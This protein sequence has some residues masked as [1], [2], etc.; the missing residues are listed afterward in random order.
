MGNAI[1]PCHAANEIES[2]SRGDVLQMRLLLPDIM[3][4]THPHDPDSLR[5]GPLNTRSRGLDLLKFLGL[6]SL[7]P[8]HQG[9]VFG[10]WANRHG[11]T[12]M[13]N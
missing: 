6:F 1:E 3:G 11:A 8:L 13:A 5:D 4:T 10:L 2:S 9:L 12:C 7:S